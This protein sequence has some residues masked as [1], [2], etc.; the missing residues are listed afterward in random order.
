MRLKFSIGLIFVAFIYSSGWF[1]ASEWVRA[2]IKVL[3]DRAGM[4][5][6]DI[7]LNYESL[8]RSGF[9]FALDW[10]MKNPEIEMEFLDFNV[11]ALAGK[12]TFSIQPFGTQSIFAKSQNTTVFLANKKRKLKLK[13]KFNSSQFQFSLDLKNILHSHFTTEDFSLHKAITGNTD[14]EWRAVL[15][16]QNFSGDIRIPRNKKI[17]QHHTE[18]PFSFL[19]TDI[20]LPTN[21]IFRVTRLDRLFGTMNLRGKPGKFSLTD[22]ITWRDNGGV[23]DI[24]KIQLNKGPYNLEF[25]GTLALDAALKPM[26]AGTITFTGLDFFLAKQEQAGKLSKSQVKLAKLA[27]HLISKPSTKNGIKMTRVPI[28][29]QNGELRLG[30]FRL[31]DLPGF[32]R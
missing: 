21:N 12:I 28:T 4:T 2:E 5:N 20:S 15:E 13:T 29:A 26:G 8:E 11:L 18:Y 31:F 14:E 17:I 30:S 16:T 1:I 6:G 32:I 25:Q 10:H 7:K 9:P 22:L 3:T 23:L 24:K 27:I 19:M